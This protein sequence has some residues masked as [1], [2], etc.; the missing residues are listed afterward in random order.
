MLVSRLE[1]PD[2][3]LDAGI[4]SYLLVIVAWLAEAPRWYR[5]GHGLLLDGDGGGMGANLSD[6]I[7]WTLIVLALWALPVGVL[8]AAAGS[9]RPAARMLA[10]TPVRSPHPERH[11]STSRSITRRAQRRP[12]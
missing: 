7:W 11:T 8:G 2:T 3:T 10:S 12:G 1:Q 6:A 9:P 4:M 5:Q